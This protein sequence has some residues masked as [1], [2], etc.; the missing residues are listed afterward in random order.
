MVPEHP[1]F[2]FANYIFTG[3]PKYQGLKVEACR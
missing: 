1:V 3:N 2:L